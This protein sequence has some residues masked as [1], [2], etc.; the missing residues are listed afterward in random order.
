MPRGLAGH[1]LTSSSG[2]RVIAKALG[3]HSLSLNSER[4]SAGRLNLRPCDILDWLWKA[5]TQLQPHMGVRGM[6]RGEKSR[7][8]GWSLRA[9]LR[10]RCLHQSGRLK[11]MLG[12]VMPTYVRRGCSCCLCSRILTCSICS[13]CC[14]AQ[15]GRVPLSL[16]TSICSCQ[17]IVLPHPAPQSD[18]ESD[19]YMCHT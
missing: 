2:G 12:H 19:V 18:H 14:K 7:A 8:L 9:C 13:K 16:H 11:V 5:G 1:V 3:H 10:T 15:C 17:S 6:L 4:S